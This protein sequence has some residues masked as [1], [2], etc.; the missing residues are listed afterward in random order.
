[1]NKSQLIILWIG[2]AFFIFCSWNP[3]IAPHTRYKSKEREYTNKEWERKLSH[4]NLGLDDSKETLNKAKGEI[5]EKRLEASKSRE[6]TPPKSKYGGPMVTVGEKYPLREHTREELVSDL[7]LEYID[8]LLAGE[9]PTKRETSSYVCFRRP[10]EN[11][12]TSLLARLLG[13]TVITVL[14]VYTLGDKNKVK[15]KEI[16][17]PLIRFKPKMENK[18]KDE[19]KE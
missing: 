18:P 6:V 8:M 1:M 19:Q 17:Q 15:V 5:I 4:Y 7:K 10:F 3:A 11:S 13:V 14:V 9:R 12:S 16:L 2:A